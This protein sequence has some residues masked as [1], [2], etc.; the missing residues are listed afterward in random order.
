MI[1]VQSDRI[2]C[3]N[4]E[5]PHNFEQRMHE[6]ILLKAQSLPINMIYVNLDTGFCFS[7]RKNV[8][9]KCL[10][11]FKDLYRNRKHFWSRV[12]CVN[13]WIICFICLHIHIHVWNLYLPLACFFLVHSFF[14]LRWIAMEMFMMPE[15]VSLRANIVC[16]GWQLGN[17][18]NQQK[19][20]W[21]Y[22]RFCHSN[23]D[24]SLFQLNSIVNTAFFAG[25]SH[26]PVILPEQSQESV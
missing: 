7:S 9:K 6:T 22:C 12:D 14:A 3:T 18:L 19:S 21:F 2:Q 13:M 24:N 25:I 5:T 11:W 1:G 16:S 23:A 26:L 10:Q 4:T 17:N 8:W 15:K 20:I